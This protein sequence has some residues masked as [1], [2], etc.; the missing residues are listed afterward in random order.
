MELRFIERDGKKILQQKNISVSASPGVFKVQNTWMDVPCEPE[1]PSTER[2]RVCDE[3]IN[4]F[5][6]TGE[7]E[8]SHIVKIIGKIRDR[9]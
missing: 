8:T 9:K 6:S 2:E 3:L 7:W 1:Q 4:I 5:N